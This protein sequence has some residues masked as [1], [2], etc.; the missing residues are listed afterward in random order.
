MAEWPRPT[1]NNRPLPV[2]IVFLH[3]PEIAD[4]SLVFLQCTKVPFVSLVPLYLLLPLPKP[5]PIPLTY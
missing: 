3:D 2:F 5:D 4:F 1:I